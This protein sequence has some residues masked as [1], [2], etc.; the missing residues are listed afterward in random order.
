MGNTRT[1]IRDV[2]EEDIARL[3]RDRYRTGRGYKVMDYIRTSFQENI[4][5]QQKLQEIHI[6]FLPSR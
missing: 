6:V 1:I 3:Y 4:G 2:R 5:L